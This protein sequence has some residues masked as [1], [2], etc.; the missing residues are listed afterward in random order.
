MKVRNYLI[1]ILAVCLIPSNILALNLN[2]SEWELKILVEKANIRMEPDEKS[3]VVTYVV[4][5]AMLKSYELTGAW[6]RVIIGSDK[7][8]FVFLGYIHVSDVE[9]VKE[10]LSQEADFWKYEEPGSFQGIGLS[11]KLTG[12]MS[13]FSGGDMGVGTRGMYDYNSNF[14]VSQGFILES[15]FKP[16]HFGAEVS[17]DIIYNLNPKFGIGIGSGFI[18]ARSQSILSYSEEE[19]MYTPFQMKSQPEIRV[20]PL[21]VGMFFSFPIHRLF[22]I[23]INAGPVLYFAKYSY[24][25]GSDRDN[26]DSLYQEAT[27]RQMGFQGGIGLEIN[28]NQRAIFLIECYGRYAKI[29]N[30]Q[31][32]ARIND[33]ELNISGLVNDNISIEE[34]TLYFL[35]R[36][37][38]PGLA[39]LNENAVGYENIRYAVFD[40]SGFNIRAGIKFRF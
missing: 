26:L 14:L 37:T 12:G 25:L 10:K 3:P 21:R 15:F 35:K 11:L 9:I 28:L 23:T 2:S 31:G 39:I 20:V 1:V 32:M 8:G 4:R 27:A 19:F 6:F 30:F 34:G 7:D 16:F 29:S 24:T 33:W 5:G 40:L 17:G 36:Q 22:D 18:F 38:Y 13:Y